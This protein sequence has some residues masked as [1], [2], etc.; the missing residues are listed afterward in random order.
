LEGEDIAVAILELDSGALVT[1]DTAWCAAGEQLSMRF[2]RGR[3]R[4]RGT[5][6]NGG[7]GA[8]SIVPDAQTARP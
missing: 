4:C 3:R 7:N 8:D 5:I 6:T 1:L 2:R